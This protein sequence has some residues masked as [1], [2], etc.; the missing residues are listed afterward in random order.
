[1]FI[2]KTAQILSSTDTNISPAI[3]IESVYYEKLDG[4]PTNAS[5]YKQSVSKHMAI[6]LYMDDTTNTYKVKETNSSSGILNIPFGIQSSDN[7]FNGSTS[8]TD[9]V[10]SGYVVVPSDQQLKNPMIGYANNIEYI[11]ANTMYSGDDTSYMA[12]YL[13]YKKYSISDLL[14]NYI[15][16]TTLEKYINWIESKT[17]QKKEDVSTDSSITYHK[18]E[19]EKQCKDISDRISNASNRY[20]DI[21]S[22]SYDIIDVTD[23]DLNEIKDL[24]SAKLLDYGNIYK[25]RYNPNLNDPEFYD[26]EFYLYLR[27]TSNNEFAPVAIAAK[28]EDDNYFDGQRLEDWEILYDISENRITYMKDEYGNEAPFDFKNK[29]IDDSYLFSDVAVSIDTDALYMIQIG[30]DANV[31]DSSL[32]HDVSVLTD[33]INNSGIGQQINN[34][35]I[36]RILDLYKYTIN[37]SS[38]I[39]LVFKKEHHNND[40]INSQYLVNSSDLLDSSIEIEPKLGLFFDNSVNL[41]ELS[42]DTFASI[43]IDEL[44]GLANYNQIDFEYIRQTNPYIAYGLSKFMFTSEF[45]SDSTWQQWPNMFDNTVKRYQNESGHCYMSL[46]VFTYVTDH[47]AGVEVSSGGWINNV[48]TSTTSSYIDA[49]GLGVRY[50]MIPSSY[51][52]TSFIRGPKDYSLSSY[53]KNNSIQSEKVLISGNLENCYIGPEN[54]SI[55]LFN[56]KDKPISDIIMAGN[57]SGISITGP[58]KN[59]QIKNNNGIINIENSYNVNIGSNNTN[60]N[61]INSSVLNI[62]NNCVD[63]NVQKSTNNVIYNDCSN[64]MISNYS[65]YNKIYQNNTGIT[66]NNTYMVTIAQESS[67]DT[68]ALTYHDNHSFY[69][70]QHMK[71]MRNGVSYNGRISGMTLISDS[72]SKPDIEITSQRCYNSSLNVWI[73]PS[74]T[75]ST[76]NYTKA[77]TYLAEPD[78]PNI[79]D[80]DV[81]DKTSGITINNVS[82]DALS[83]TMNFADGGDKVYDIWYE[84]DKKAKLQNNFTVSVFSGDISKSKPLYIDTTE[85]YGDIGSSNNMYIVNSSSAIYTYGVSKK[86]PEGPS[87]KILNDTNSINSSLNFVVTGYMASL[88]DSYKL[89]NT[90]SDVSIIGSISLKSDASLGIGTGNNII[91]NMTKPSEYECLVNL[92]YKLN[93]RQNVDPLALSFY[94]KNKIVKTF[95]IN[96]ASIYNLISVMITYYRNSYSNS[97][98]FLCPENSFIGIVEC[99]DHRTSNSSTGNSNRSVKCLGWNYGSN[100]IRIPIDNIVD[101]SYKLIPSIIPASSLANSLVYKVNSENLYD[102]NALLLYVRQSGQDRYGSVSFNYNGSTNINLET[103]GINTDLGGSINPGDGM[104]DAD[105]GVD[106]GF[107]NDGPDKGPTLS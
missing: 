60:I 87:I 64:C 106:I 14:R 21:V 91:P 104:G 95:D 24:I 33:K 62:S 27:A 7:L 8:L 37:G 53:V 105:F 18:Q 3:G 47:C 57:N 59:I 84:Y 25:I 10:T 1:M 35:S 44:Y 55:T 40:I 32:Y 75:S 6:Q 38:Y 79:K 90:S 28:I 65:N 11:R 74:R 96:I 97:T 102:S 71:S 76:I 73:L 77:V 107:G 67:E 100:K 99:E 81:Y 61:I 23:T 39:D 82:I 69:T 101:S 83:F 26:H 94:Y 12:A 88:I 54:N 5:I 85:D 63:I 89:T 78:Q 36:G 43:T 68:P 48:S 51:G 31:N 30:W 29:K 16:H 19:K 50:D 66:M 9:G 17:R 20:N 93:Y 86:L 52:S 46:P 49:I 80:I 4:S 98:I 58:C 70:S 41:I 92:S 22:T 2:G 72:S 45:P 103:L 42:S 15:S 34:A 56:T 13:G